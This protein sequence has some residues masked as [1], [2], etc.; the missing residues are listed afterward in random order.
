MLGLIKGSK[1]HFSPPGFVVSIVDEAGVCDIYRIKERFPSDIS[2][3]F[4]SVAHS[5]SCTQR[6]LSF[7]MSD[8]TSALT[9][10]TRHMKPASTLYRAVL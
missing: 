6:V 1:V 8:S 5:D 4:P 3:T 7:L 2:D 10:R 9:M